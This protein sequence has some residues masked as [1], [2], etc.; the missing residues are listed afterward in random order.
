MTSFKNII[1]NRRFV[2]PFLIFVFSLCVVFFEFLNIPKNTT[3]DE[4]EFAK[5]ALQL[6]N[7]PYTPYSMYATGHATLYFYIILFSFKLF[8]VSLFSLRLP[9]AIF[10]V[11]NPLI[12]Y[13]IMKKVFKPF[14]HPEFI[15]R[16]LNNKKMPK[17]SQEEQ[18]RHDNF[19]LQ[20]LPLILSF[21]FI[22][23][24]WYFNF[25]R[26]GF[27][28]TFLL[29]L[30][31]T[32]LLFILL[33]SEKKQI[34]YLILSGIFTGLAY[35][36]YQPGR[37]FILVPF[38]FLVTKVLINNVVPIKVGVHQSIL[39][40]FR[41]KSGMT[42]LLYFLIPFII[43]ISP[44]TFYLNIHKDTRFYQQFY[45]DNHEMTLQEKETFFVRNLSSTIGIFNIK[46]DVNGRHNYPNKSALNPIL[47]ILFIVGLCISVK[48]L[49]K[50]NNQMFLLWF[51]LS[52]APTLVTYPWENPNMLRTFTVIPSVIYFIGLAIKTILDIKIIQKIIYRKI[53]FMTIFGLIFISSVYELRTYFVHQSTVFKE[54]FEAERPLKTYL[55]IKNEK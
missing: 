55:N 4:I 41:I 23:L 22:T 19:L 17:P 33:F 44:L 16:S 12:F 38:F 13:F 15:S 25:A 2:F 42:I 14:C 26:F 21:I 3:F 32:S 27:E 49:K 45:P 11:I 37:I 35:N 7:K 8:G 24:R 39:N 54:A 1:F 50:N 48:G 52:L 20:Y 30:E 29:F 53:L 10:G 34:K 43:L 28:V 47:G 6:N 51:F 31:L 36:S 5:L 40:R 18:V 9:S 46:G